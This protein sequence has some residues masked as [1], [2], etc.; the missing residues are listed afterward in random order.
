MHCILIT[1][2]NFSVTKLD[3]NDAL[4]LK[5]FCGYAGLHK[6]WNFDEVAKICQV[7]SEC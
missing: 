7:G 3:L 1:F 2:Q 5:P 4:D 6:L